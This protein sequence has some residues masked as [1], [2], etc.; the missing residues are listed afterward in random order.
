MA[1][2][3]LKKK[4]FSTSF[5]NLLFKYR[6]SY[7]P[8]KY[9]LFNPKGSIKFKFGLIFLNVENFNIDLLIT[10]LLI[11]LKYKYPNVFSPLIVFDI[12][13]ISDFKIKQ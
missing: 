7:K 10:K 8:T 1:D 6:Y 3:H 4:E 13:S 11:N 9:K 5:Q 2:R 12:G